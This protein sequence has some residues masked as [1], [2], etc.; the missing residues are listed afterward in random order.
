VATSIL[1]MTALRPRT[2]KYRPARRRGEA[3]LPGV[4]P[5][6][7]KRLFRAPVTTKRARSRNAAIRTRR[8]VRHTPTVIADYV[9][10]GAGSAGAVLAHRLSA[11]PAVRVLLIEAGRRSMG[12]KSSVPAASYLLMGDPKADWGYLGEPDGS[13][14]G[15]RICW[16]SGR[17]LGGSSAINGMVYFRGARSNF[18]GWAQAGCAGWS[19]D[20]VLPYFRRSENFAGAP[21]S[22]HGQ[23]GPL[24]VSPSRV[25]QELAEP[26]R[27][28]CAE[29]GLALLDDYSAGDID[30]SFLT[31][32]T[33]RVGRRSSTAT[34][35]LDSARHRANLTILTD[36]TVERILFEGRRATG[37]RVR[38]DEGQENCLARREVIVCAGAI[39]SPALLLRSGIGPG[40][41]LAALGL[42]V[43][44]DLSGVGQNFHDHNAVTVSK[45]VSSATYNTGM[46]PIRLLG[47][48]LNYL[49]FKR[50]RLS[51]IAVHA[52]AYARSQAEL[53]EPDICT[54]FF[55]L[56][57]DLAGST[58]KL[59]ERGGITIV[60]HPAQ[61]QARGRLRLAS[62][63]P[64]TPP[65]IEYGLLSDE[66]DVDTLV[67]GCRFIESL[68]AAPALARYV[69]GNYDPP[70]ALK[71]RE[72]W[73]NYLRARTS[74]AYHPVGTCRMGVD[75]RAVVTPELKVRG[76]EGLRVADASIMPRITSGNTNAPTIMIG[77]KA[78]DMVLAGR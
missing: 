27:Q 78:A 18:D 24:S 58:P 8:S 65:I 69:V 12:L 47:P 13:I 33:T 32:G 61:T 48:L 35:F 19:F 38:R 40:S 2:R 22:V 31:L 45:E 67:S 36:C 20:E 63:D 75:D 70:Q 14:G 34:A 26:Y 6:A 52:M 46:D 66:R 56:A 42:P 25:L 64:A 16:S 76:L 53:A 23:G 1:G 57:L 77:E 50:G 7:V 41:E 71:S 5:G 39:G 4:G 60:T 37:V 3:G 62:P 29:R 11:D 51:T 43:V 74:I 17:M 15:R 28:A 44:A 21:S 9:I 55:P 30:G 68:F 49:L 59:R 72:D 54:S 73:V 10:V